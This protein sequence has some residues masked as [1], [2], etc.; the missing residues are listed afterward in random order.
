MKHAKPQQTGRVKHRQGLADYLALGADRSLEKLYQWYRE[1]VPKPPGRS[2]IKIWST[3]YE[4]QAKAAQHDERVAGN[5]SQKVEEAAV[6]ETWDRVKDLTAVAQRSIQKA[7]DA[8]KD[9][10][11]EVKDPYA[12]AAL[13]NAAMSSI[14]TV[15]LLAGRATG[16][17]ETAFPKNEVP[18]WL[19]ERLA[20]AASPPTASPADNEI[21]IPETATRSRRP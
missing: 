16:R 21:D 11:M 5:V 18:E 8:L 4:W 9:D 6:E 2:I 3:R 20:A 13:V 14:K 15:E 7:L 19:S 1:N 10:N 12:V 17:L